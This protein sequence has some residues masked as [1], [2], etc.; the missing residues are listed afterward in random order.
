MST[1]TPYSTFYHVIKQPCYG[2]ETTYGVPLSGSY[3]YIAPQAAFMP[4]F[5]MGDVATRVLGSRDVRKVVAGAEIG[6][7]TLRFNPYNVTFLKYAFN[8]GSSTGSVT[9]TIDKSLTIA[10]S[11]RINNIDYVMLIP[12]CKIERATVRCAAGGLVQ[13]E[14]YC[15][16]RKPQLSGS[17]TASGVTFPNDAGT[18]P[19]SFQ[20]GGSNPVAIGTPTPDV[21]NIR[22][23]VRNNLTPIYVLGSKIIKDIVPMERQLQLVWSQL[24]KG[25]TEFTAATG[26]TDQ[27]ISWTLQTSGPVFRFGATRITRLLNLPYVV[28]SVAVETWGAECET[29]SL[30][31]T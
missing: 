31:S 26:S 7:F 22:V 18:A 9:G 1:G 28:G 16:G 14:V 29:G 2:E 27:V 23:A 4:E 8:T 24:Q 15:I 13:A 19:Y 3:T 10:S 25:I 17:T 12:G 11:I 21:N 5:D 30:D 6:G 20:D